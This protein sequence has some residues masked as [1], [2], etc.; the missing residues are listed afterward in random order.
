MNSYTEL[1]EKAQAEMLAGL[2]K[3]QELN[4]ATLE[5]MKELNL[6]TPAD[7][8]ERTFAFTNQL[9]ETRKAYMLKLADLITPAKN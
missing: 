9:L 5:S 4:L 1:V 2:K 3:A 6:P 8:V 7:V